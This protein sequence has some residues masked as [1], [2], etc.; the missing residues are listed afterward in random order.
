MLTDAVLLDISQAQRQ[1]DQL[2]AELR[3]LSQPVRVPVDIDVDQGIDELRRDVQGA[4]AGFG[5]LNAELAETDR[6]LDRV[7]NSADRAGRELET[8]GRRGIASFNGMAVAA[9]AFGV[10]IAAAV[11]IRAFAGFANDAIQSASSFEE[12]LSKT[13]VVFGGFSD[14]IEAFARTGP[15]ALGLAN[16]E[17]LAFTSTFGNLFVALGLSQEAAAD[18]SPAI[19]QLGSD[20]ASFNDLNV[21]DALEKLRSGLV[22]EAEPLRAL[23]VNINESLVQAKAL[24]LGLVGVNGEVSEAAKVQARYALILEQTTTA[25]GDFARTADGVANT[26]RTLSGLWEDAQVVLGQ[27]LLPAYQQLLD[28][29]PGLITQ[30]A[31]LA[32]SFAALGVSLANAA[33]DSA[34]FLAFLLDVA[35][36]LPGVASAFGDIFTGDFLQA[37]DNLAVARLQTG[38]INDLREGVDPALALANALAELNRQTQSRPEDFK[39]FSDQFIAIANLDPK[40]AAELGQQLRR[41]G[42]DAGFSAPQVQ[43]LR[44][45]LS[46]LTAEAEGFSR[47]TPGGSNLPGSDPQTAADITAAAAATAL[48]G[49][50]LRQ[51]PSDLGLTDPIDKLDVFA[52]ALS[53]ANDALQTEAGEIQD[54]LEAFF[55]DINQTLANQVAFQTNLNI[56]RQRGLFN[57]ADLFQ[58]LGPEGGG[59]LLAD[60]VTDPAAAAEEEAR[61]KAHA[62]A[63]AIAEFSAFD[64][65]L[66]AAITGYDPTPVVIPLVFG[67]FPTFAAPGTVGGIPVFTGGGGGD[68]NIYFNG[69][70]P[71]ELPSTAERAVQII[72]SGVNQSRTGPS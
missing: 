21:A 55:A 24:E 64:A 25:Q 27:A 56:L 38:F 19:V 46:A 52:G 50:Q 58:G 63:M 28:I 53:A 32:P 39:K 68:T 60:A 10:A 20:L 33:E 51:F 17:A 65:Q 6:E 4:D 62:E 14:D 70:T 71:D 13:R 36:A 42:L 9:G 40:R 57:L 12:A 45:Q 2:E 7:R 31:D 29:L 43:F 30:V 35:R 66:K 41:T 37:I 23:G 5:E 34:P 47:R 54:N 16:R 61:L 59:Q 67:E 18:L 11:G 44:E 72:N 1:I 48:L 22:G 49:E 3:R 26:Q 8:T 15:Q 69:V